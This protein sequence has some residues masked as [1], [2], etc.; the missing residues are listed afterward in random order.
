[1]KVQIAGVAVVMIGT[2]LAGLTIES[3]PSTALLSSMF[4]AIGLMVYA[5]AEDRGAPW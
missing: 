1:M 2:I 4:A 5:A 3:H